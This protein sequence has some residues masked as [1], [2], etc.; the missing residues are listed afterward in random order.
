MK[1]IAFIFLFLSLLVSGFSQTTYPNIFF[2][3]TEGYLV[4]KLYDD[5]PLHCDNFLKLVKEGY[6][7]NQLF[8]RVIR[9]FMIQT[10]NPNTKNAKSN[11]RLGSGGPGY[12]IPAEFN[13]NYYHKRGA[14]SAARMADNANPKK[15]SSGSQFYIVQGRTY[16]ISELNAFVQSGNHIPFSSEQIEVYTKDKGTPHLDYEYT[17]FGE[18]IDGFDVLDKIASK[19]T[20]KYDR[21]VNDVKIIKA[22]PWKK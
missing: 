22:Y 21:P 10:G 12:T 18:L 2:E 4:L 1:K 5:T 17:V 3:T 20:D 7:N 14:L 9:N 8:H 13:T 11:E 15:E 6:Y 16:T 19:E